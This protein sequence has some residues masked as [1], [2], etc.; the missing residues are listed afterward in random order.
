MPF[1]ASPTF[2]FLYRATVAYFPQAFLFLVI[3]IYFFL[4]IL[5]VIVHIMFTKVEKLTKAS[6]KAA[7]AGIKT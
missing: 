5:V 1:A 7:E 6:E 4:L 3:A 2:G